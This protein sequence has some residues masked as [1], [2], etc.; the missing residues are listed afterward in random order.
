MR[1]VLEVLLAEIE[2][3]LGT[4]ERRRDRIRE[5][6]ARKAPE[7]P[8]GETRAMKL[9]EEH[10]GEHLKEA[11]SSLWMLAIY[12]SRTASKRTDCGCATAHWR[13]SSCLSRRKRP[14][15]AS[16]V[17]RRDR[18]TVFRRSQKTAASTWPRAAKPISP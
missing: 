8:E 4:L 14:S 6:L 12:A 13:G 2:G 3:Q 15:S 18:A 11:S 9:A 7:I 17:G 10:L 16:S 1:D 5:M